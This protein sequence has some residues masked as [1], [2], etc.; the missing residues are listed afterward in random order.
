MVEQIGLQSQRLQH[1]V[2]HCISP[3]AGSIAPNTAAAGQRQCR[4]GLDRTARGPG[5]GRRTGS[6]RRVWC[7][8]GSRIADPGEH[9][10]TLAWCTHDGP[11]TLDRWR[12]SGIVTNARLHGG[13]RAQSAQMPPHLP[14]SPR[15][16]LLAPWSIPGVA[17][18]PEEAATCQRN[19]TVPIRCILRP[20]RA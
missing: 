11:P 3:Q 8:H 2:L 20:P 10:P 13:R 18:A 12:R 5:T 16:I 6:S 4:R 9:Q 15:A 17:N 7:P 1:H 19:S 14:R